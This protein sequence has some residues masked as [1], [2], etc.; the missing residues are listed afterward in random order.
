MLN[1]EGSVK[2]IKFKRSKYKF[3]RAAHFFVHFFAFILHDYNV[4]R[5]CRMCLPK[6]LFPVF[7]FGFIIFSLPFIFTFLAS[8][9]YS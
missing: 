9:C 5:N 8:P 7:M 2:N 4:W 3:A 1:R 6:I